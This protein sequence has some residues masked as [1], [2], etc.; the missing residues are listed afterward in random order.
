MD[1]KSEPE[2]LNSHRLEPTKV[3]INYDSTD[4]IGG[5]HLPRKYTWV[6]HHI[7][8]GKE[9]DQKLMARAHDETYVTGEWV[10]L[11]TKDSRDTKPK[12]EI[13]LKVNIST[14]RSPNI[15]ARTK[16]FRD[17][18]GLI[19]EEIAFAETALL[20]A[21][22]SHARVGIV[23]DFLAKDKASNKTEYW[24]RL[25]Y[26]TPDSMRDK[27]EVA[28]QAKVAT[29]ISKKP[30]DP[31]DRDKPAMHGKRRHS[32]PS[33][34]SSRD[35]VKRHYRDFAAPNSPFNPINGYTIDQIKLGKVRA[36]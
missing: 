5:L 8:V 12:Y 10:R 23:I 3:L 25:G 36:Q 15:E 18:L 29:K 34:R 14:E 9:Y 27:S 7:S 17:R 6:S 30:K 26:W 35:F 32:D 20:K 2:K 24:H 19:L 28:S 16:Y 13:H 11:Q 22:P 31:K 21:H 4:A 33:A 1:K